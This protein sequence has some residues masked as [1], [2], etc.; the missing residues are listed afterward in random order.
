MCHTHVRGRIMMPEIEMKM[1]LAAEEVDV[2]EDVLGWI[3]GRGGAFVPATDASISCVPGCL[4][5]SMIQ[6]HAKVRVA[7]A[8]AFGFAFVS[9]HFF[10]CHFPFFFC[11]SSAWAWPC[12]QLRGFI[13]HANTNRNSRN[14]AQEL[15][16]EQYCH[17]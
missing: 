16:Q 15:K 7:V 5:P 9:L 2:D 13:N 1:G 8:I 14:G 6:N 17:Y 3:A 10:S 12:N 4:L 11:W